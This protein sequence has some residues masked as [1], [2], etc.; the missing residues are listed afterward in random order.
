MSDHCAPSPPVVVGVDGSKAAIDATLWAVDDAVSRDIPLRLIHA[1]DPATADAEPDTAA[2]ELA[3]AE[4]AVRYACMAVESTDA[5]VKIEVEN[6][7]EQPTQALRDVAG[8]GPTAVAVASAAQLR[9]VP[10]RMLTTWQDGAVADSGRSAAVQLDR[11]LAQSKNRHRDVDVR[12]MN[13]E[14]GVLHFLGENANSI[15]LLVAG[16]E[17]AHGVSAL[18]GPPGSAALHDAACSVLICEPQNVL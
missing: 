5:P 9:D 8:F 10:L 3:K 13:A 11:R 1:I 16:C 17:R 7:Q 6:L 18:V 2:R 12:A 4:V 14:R 15:Q